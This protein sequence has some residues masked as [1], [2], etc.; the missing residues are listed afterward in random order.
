MKLDIS[1]RAVPKG[2]AKAEAARQRKVALARR[3]NVPVTLAKVQKYED[4]QIP[5]SPAPQD[6]KA[7]LEAGGQCKAGQ[8]Q[9]R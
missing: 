6:G 2:N 9:A 1:L 3:K 4:E 7:N 8:A 5:H